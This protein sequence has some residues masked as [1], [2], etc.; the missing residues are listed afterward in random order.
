MLQEH[1]TDLVYD[2]NPKYKDVSFLRQR[3]S[4]LTWF[5]IFVVLLRMLPSRYGRIHFDARLRY[6]HHCDILIAEG[7]LNMDFNTHALATLFQWPQDKI[8]W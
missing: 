4:M 6:S 8:G 1:V 2:M 5:A 7:Q 3:A